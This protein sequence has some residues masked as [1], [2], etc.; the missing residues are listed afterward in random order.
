MN[1]SSEVF[2]V[3]HVNITQR[4]PPKLDERTDV[5]ILDPLCRRDNSLLTA[6]SGI[7]IPKP[8]VV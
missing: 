6:A 1:G 7:R 3:V 2:G 5:H 8:D 4:I